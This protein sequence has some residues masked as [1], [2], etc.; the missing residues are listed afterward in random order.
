MISTLKSVSLINPKLSHASMPL[1]K[2]PDSL[3]FHPLLKTPNS[4][5]SVV[6]NGFLTLNRRTSSTPLIL[7]FA[8]APDDSQEI[9]VGSGK[10]ELGVGSEESQEV[11][12]Q[13][14]DT[15][16][17]QAKKFQGVS[18]EAYEEYSKKAIVIL[19]D[20]QKQLKVQ[21]DKARH[22]LTVAAKEISEEGKEYIVT[23]AEKSP[24]VKEIVET[25]ASPTDD[26]SHLS[27]VRDFYVGIPY[28]LIL[29]IGG[30]LSF[31]VTGSLAAVR[32]GM[33]LGGLLLFL[34]ISSLRA[35]RRGESSPRALN[36][37]AAIASI[38]FL[39][40]IILLGKGSPPITR[41]TTLISGA[42]AAFYVY[43]L[44][45]ER[46]PLGDSN[47]ETGPGN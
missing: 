34:S 43:R 10:D 26:L 1:S 41:F 14:L 7:A 25:F 37:Q 22:D 46:K 36:G 47:L 15:F 13:A 39:R 16:R 29:S 42:V 6:S 44:V 31:M 9:E 12:K 4:T 35:Y 45:L 21:A 30:F 18:Q 28:G 2:A 17:E 32:F 3:K 11:W 20:A 38:L 24:E 8:A 27:G 19:K 33:F 40:E 23:A 5:R